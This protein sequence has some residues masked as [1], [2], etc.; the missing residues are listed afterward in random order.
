MKRVP[1]PRRLPERK[2]ESASEKLAGESLPRANKC[3]I[4]SHRPIVFPRRAESPNESGQLPFNNFTRFLTRLDQEKV[5]EYS[6]RS[7]AT[8]AKR[9]LLDAGEIIAM[10][11]SIRHGSRCARLC[12]AS[13]SRD[14]AESTPISARVSARP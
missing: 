11:L 12:E 8:M 10:P 13:D 7:P 14:S 6:R 4:E 1:P 2:G 9:S 3:L 5:Q